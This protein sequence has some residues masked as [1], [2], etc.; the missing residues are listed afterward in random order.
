M[1]AK[2]EPAQEKGDVYE[3]R[4]GSE[5]VQ[6]A[7]KQQGLTST[8]DVPLQASDEATMAGRSDVNSVV[9]EAVADTAELSVLVQVLRIAILTVLAVVLLATLGRALTY[10]ESDTPLSIWVA[11]IFLDSILLVILAGTHY[12]ER[13]WS[14]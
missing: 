12:Y 9:E 11:V 14:L 8:A 13:R 6:V 5:E 1:S 4:G 7:A 2:N 3:P 10:R